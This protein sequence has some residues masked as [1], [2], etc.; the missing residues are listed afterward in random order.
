MVVRARSLNKVLAEGSG[1]PVADRGSKVSMHVGTVTKL[2]HGP[3]FVNQ[4]STSY[5]EIENLRRQK[6]TDDW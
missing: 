1:K 3:V 4:L 2:V 6:R 5:V